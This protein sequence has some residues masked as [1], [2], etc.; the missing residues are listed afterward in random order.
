MTTD[1]PAPP[2]P[3]GQA[4]RPTRRRRGRRLLTRYALLWG[5]PVAAAL[6]WVAVWSPPSTSAAS[7]T[8]A[9]TSG[10]GYPRYSFKGTSRPGYP[11]YKGVTGRSPG[12]PATSGL[13]GLSGELQVSGTTGG[14]RISHA[15]GR[16]GKGTKLRKQVNGVYRISSLAKARTAATS[17]L[18][19]GEKA[20]TDEATPGAISHGTINAA[21]IFQDHCAAC[22]G[23][24]ARGTVR[25]PSLV[26]VGEAMVDFQLSTGRMPKKVYGHRAEPYTPVLSVLEIKALDRY[27]TALAAKGG[28]SIPSV[29]ASIGSIAQGGVLFRENCAACHGWGGA[30]GELVN[31]PVPRITEATPLVLGEAVRS[32]PEQMPVFGTEVVSKSG[33]NDIAAYLDYIKHPDNAGGNGLSHLGPVASGAVA[34]IVGALLIVAAM[35][36]IG[37]RA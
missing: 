25:G 34:W 6:V 36:W 16:Y 12:P 22:H 20:Q 33:L 35:R 9:G 14:A 13:S 27:V 21:M 10:R 17:I 31:R 15:Y 11:S 19:S 3:E 30:G 37:K 2:A 8:T 23:E 7:V 4:P 1:H 18:R 26:G 29:N 24:T 5:V 32:G 28:P